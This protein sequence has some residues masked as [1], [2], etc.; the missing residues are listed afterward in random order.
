MRYSVVPGQKLKDYMKNKL[1]ITSDELDITVYRT[2]ELRPI[3][4]PDNPK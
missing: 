3:V 4:T 1:N 2:D